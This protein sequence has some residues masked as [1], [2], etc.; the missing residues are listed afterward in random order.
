MAYHKIKYKNVECL[1]SLQKKLRIANPRVLHPLS[2]FEE[3]RLHFTFALHEAMN[4]RS[5]MK[6]NQ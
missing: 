3:Q 5:Q 4:K 2:V 1:L 6:E